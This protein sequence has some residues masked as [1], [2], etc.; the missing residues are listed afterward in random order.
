[1]IELPRVRSP[2]LWAGVQG[3]TAIRAV[4]ETAHRINQD[5]AIS[6][7]PVRS[8]PIEGHKSDRNPTGSARAADATSHTIKGI[9]SAAH[10][11]PAGFA[12]HD[13]SIRPRTNQAYA[14]VMP[15]VGHNCPVTC[16]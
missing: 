4:G 5:A 10:K 2:D 7:A 11:L 9:D 14:V 6:A 1:M 13:R 15:Q 8:K 12:R 3:P 16:A